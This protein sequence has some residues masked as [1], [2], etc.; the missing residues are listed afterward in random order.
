MGRHQVVAAGTFRLSAPRR[1]D[2][3]WLFDL[4]DTLHDAGHSALPHINAA[5]TAYI[6]QLLQLSEPEAGALRT[7]YW[8]RYGATLLGLIKHHGVQAAHFLEATHQLPG[9]EQRLRLNGPDRAA[10]ARLPGRKYIVTNAPRGY[11]L[12]VLS[13]LRLL[14]LFDGVICIE[15]LCMFG[16]MRPKPD[17]RMFRSLVARLRTTPA[18]CVLV[19]DTLGHQRQ[20][21]RVGLRTAW[22]QRYLRRRPPSPHKLAVPVEN[23][24]KVSSHPCGRPL[25]VCARIKRLSSLRVFCG[26]HDD[27]HPQP[28]SFYPCQ[29]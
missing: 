21:R 10:L 17:A 2:P 5:M 9:L 4:D 28:P 19:E 18:R 11:A 15:D 20:A 3:V 14:R 27:P 12:R 7:H 6:Q 24:R 22:M 16:Q 26:L 8:Q 29:S 13:A 25:Y 1:S 23:T